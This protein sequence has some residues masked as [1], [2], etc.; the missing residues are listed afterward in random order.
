MN[1]LVLTGRFGMGHYSA[2]DT[3]AKDVL[4]NYPNA[5]VTV[6]DI[7]EYSIPHFSKALYDSYKLL[8]K[9]GSAL[10]NLYYKSTEKKQGAGRPPFCPYFLSAL[11]QLI[12]STR[13][14]YII[15]TL[16][17]CSQ[18][19]SRYQEKYHSAIR[20]F[21]CI[22]DISTH[23]E[24]ITPNTDAYLV[25]SFSMK[26]E[27]MSRGVDGHR[28]YVGGIPVKEQFKLARYPQ[29][30]AVRNL[31][32]MGGGFG[33]IPKRMA[34][35]KALNALEGVHTT[36][37]LGNNQALYDKL[38]GRFE[39][40][41]VYGYSDQVYRFM[42]EADLIISK[43]GGITMFETI[44][45]ELPIL[46]LH[47]F[48]A[49]EIKN[50]KY[51]QSRGIGRVLWGKNIQLVEEIGRLIRDDAALSEI[52]DNMKKIKSGIQCKGICELIERREEVCA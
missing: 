29:K 52:R 32:I 49:Q 16:P 25:A 24:W 3:L 31:L 47:P 26:A 42:Q 18:L 41:T 1:V 5:H 15:S 2:A 51:I 33:L 44:Y 37:I 8:M 28:I 20:L 10:Y 4:R 43:P 34:F 13:P 35:Y 36:I 12:E 38:Y 6:E 22:T 48:L 46:V 11:E 19:F 39:N 23:N 21:T 14:D 27:L 30:K 50:A 40:I 17:F 9:T 45:A 7:F